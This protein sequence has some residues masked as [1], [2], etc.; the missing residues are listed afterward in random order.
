M[1]IYKPKGTPFYHYDFWFKGRRFRGSTEEVSAGA[2]RKVEA[3]VK[4][5][6]GRKTVMSLDAAV[7]RYWADHA[8]R[9]PSAATVDFLSKGLLAGLG[10]A[11]RLDE[12]TDNDVATFVA[13]LRGRMTDASVNRHLTI[14]RAILRMARDRWGVEV[15]MPNWKAHWLAEPAPRDRYLTPDEAE[16]LIG[17]AAPHLQPAIRFSL[18]TGVRLAN[19]IDLDWS[20]VNLRRAEVTF[21][22]KSRTPGGKPHVV[23][24]VRPLVLM[25]ANMGPA[26]RGPVFTYLDPRTKERRPVKSWRK[27]W[28]KALARAKI[29]NLRWHDL[30]HTAASWL[31]QA[32]VPLDVVRDILG[33]ASIATTLRYAHRDTSAKR[34]ALDSIAGSPLPEAVATTTPKRLKKA[35]K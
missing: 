27:A 32:G 17:H 22:I 20:Q 7:G 16:A 9:K 3:R 31:V 1:S 33:H 30:R 24:L 25:L 6:A 29:T 15:A 18:F 21:R 23:P 35:G 2:A 26:D 13:K 34:R 8:H 10:K 12:L 4:A 28:G 5:S 11:T 19:C 14:L